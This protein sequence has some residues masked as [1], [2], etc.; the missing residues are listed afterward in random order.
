M[1]YTDDNI[2]QDLFEKKPE[3]YRQLY[4]Q[5]CQP[6][7]YFSK[8]F[9][10]DPMTAEDIVSQSFLKLMEMPAK[11]PNKRS[12]KAWLYLT[13]RNHAFDL[14]RHKKVLKDHHDRILQET[15]PLDEGH[16]FE[17]EQEYHLRLAFFEKLELHI[18]NL[19]PQRSR[20]VR[21]LFYEKRSIAEVA[22]ILGI[23]ISTVKNHRADALDQ[24][25]KT[26]PERELI[27]LLIFLANMPDA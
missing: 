23:S 16:V 15:D 8:S 1:N 7:L 14:L 27:Y 24:L 22:S 9:V 20:V 26:F 6:L 5:Y 25:K 19:P 3:A 11:F 12:I 21:M 2:A 18:D 13:C 4:L 17:S 10:D